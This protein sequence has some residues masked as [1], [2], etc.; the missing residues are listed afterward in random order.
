MNIEELIYEVELPDGVSFSMNNHNVKLSGSRGELNRDFKHPKISISED[1]GKITLT[2]K[3]IRRKEK[4]LIGTWRAHLNNMAQ[5]VSSGFLYE[6][7]LY[8]LTSL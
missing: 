7:K 4:A 5:G 3:K 2:G 1:N 6:M 8:L